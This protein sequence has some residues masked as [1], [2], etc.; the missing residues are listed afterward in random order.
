MDTTVGLLLR[1]GG[2]EGN[3]TM[4][5]LP[6]RG[7]TQLQTAILAS[8]VIALI[9]LSLLAAVGFIISR[10]RTQ[11]RCLRERQDKG[12]ASTDRAQQSV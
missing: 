6:N 5:I 3:M 11:R 9:F 7:N 1:E 2:E 8:V 10:K 12:A 4:V